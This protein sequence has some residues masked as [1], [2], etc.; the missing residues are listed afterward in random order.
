[1]LRQPFRGN[2]NNKVFFTV[3]PAGLNRQTLTCLRQYFEYPRA[4]EY[5]F[6]KL[7]VYRYPGVGDRQGRCQ[8]FNRVNSYS[9][10]IG[11]GPHPGTQRRNKTVEN[12]DLHS[13]PE[14]EFSVAGQCCI[15]K[16]CSLFAVHAASLYCG[17]VSGQRSETVVWQTF[18]ITGR[19]R[20]YPVRCPT[21]TI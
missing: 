1:M 13:I 4:L 8:R 19:I 15:D 17:G 3:Y 14:R 6:I 11:S 5:R 2:V 21:S 10:T 12:G 20:S 18:A 7:P 16:L 9:H